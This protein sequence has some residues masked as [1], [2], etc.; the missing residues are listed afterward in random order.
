MNR[1]TLPKI[2]F[3]IFKLIIWGL[4]SILFVEDTLIVS[5]L[6]SWWCY[7]YLCVMFVCYLAYLA[8]FFSRTK[9][10][11]YIIFLSS[12][13]GYFILNNVNTEVYQARQ[14]SWCLQQGKIYNQQQNTC[15]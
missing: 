13:I 6:N 9:R 8:T 15:L 14:N 10:I 2:I 5:P 3:F 1:Q 11:S 12:F 7:I 4:L